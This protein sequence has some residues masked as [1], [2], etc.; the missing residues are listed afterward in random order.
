[1]QGDSIGVLG[2][3]IG[4]VIGVIGECLQGKK[5]GEFGE[6]GELQ[7]T[8]VMILCFG[9]SVRC[10]ANDKQLEPAAKCIQRSSFG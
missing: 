7:V 6:I 4:V 2:V 3:V 9:A 10:G 1:M 8:M 5:K